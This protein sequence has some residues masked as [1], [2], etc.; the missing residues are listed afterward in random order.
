MIVLYYKKSLKAK[1]WVR[2]Y[3]MH[4]QGRDVMEKEAPKL[5]AQDSWAQ[6]KIETEQR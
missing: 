4:D 2:A 6:W 5:A 3:S 1:K